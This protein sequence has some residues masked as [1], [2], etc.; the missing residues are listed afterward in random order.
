MWAMLLH[1]GGALGGL[2][3]SFGIP[4]GNFIIPLVIWLV[5]K[6]ESP[7][8][9]DQGKEAINF[10]LCVLILSILCIFTCIGAILIFPIAL[11]ALVVGIVAAIKASDGIAFRY[12][13]NFRMI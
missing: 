1:L 6:D 2:S 12:P 13:V 9:H 11:F 8:I 10:Q 3:V 7:F 4:G 5:K